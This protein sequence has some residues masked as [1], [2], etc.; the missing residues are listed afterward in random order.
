MY[1]G[2]GIR[3]A[4]FDYTSKCKQ[5]FSL[6]QYRPWL[7]DAHMKSVTKTASSP[8]LVKKILRVR[9]HFSASDAAHGEKIFFALI[10]MWPRTLIRTAHN[11]VRQFGLRFSEGG[12]RGH[13]FP[14]GRRVL[15]PQQWKYRSDKK[16]YMIQ[17][18]LL[19]LSSRFGARWAINSNGRSIVN[20]F[21]TIRRTI[22]FQ[23]S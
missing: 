4:M 10:L 11:G 14:S 5:M 1:L 15:L 16:R 9:A 2:F 22:Q 12:R 21:G 17:P 18:S 23:K 3:I 13:T 8:L 6:S 20:C 19:R 7:A